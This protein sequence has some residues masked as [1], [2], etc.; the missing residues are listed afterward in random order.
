MQ[1][2]ADFIQTTRTLLGDE[3]YARFAHALDQEPPVSIRLNPTKCRD[4]V[5]AHAK[6]QVPWCLEGYYLSERPTFTFDPLLHAGCYYVQEASSMF[7]SHVLRQMVANAVSM[8]DLC[9]AP[10]GKTTAAISALPTGSTIVANEPVR[11]RAQVLTEN[12]QKWGA[13]CCTVTSK[14]ARQFQAEQAQFDVILTDVPC[15]GEGMFR[16]D[17]NAA[18]EWSA[19]AVAK[20]QQLQRTIVADIWPCLKP[21]GLLIYSTCT[22]NTRENEEN[23]M[24]IMGEMGATLESVPIESQWGI[25]GSLLSDLPGPVYRFLPGFAQGEGL[26]MAI[27]RKP[28]V[29]VEL[30]YQQAMAYLQRQALQLPPH[31]PS[32]LVELTFMGHRLGMA[33]NIGSRANNLYPQQWR[34][35]STHIPTD[36]EAILRHT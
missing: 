12:V 27:L 5:P 15:S 35:K 28:A 31:V 30:T 19:A 1:L 2:P 34:I 32:G 6:G 3:R 17:P 11:Q 33:N 8:L 25:L 9:A 21:G 7:I 24:W 22:I 13:P 26:F 29:Q 20:C 23:V 10:G 4:L 16:K 18:S 14:Q 36:Y